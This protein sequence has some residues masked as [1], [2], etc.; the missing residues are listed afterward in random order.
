L[1]SCR[2]ALDVPPDSEE[3]FESGQ[4]FFSRP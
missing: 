3:V 4:D 2:F 1:A